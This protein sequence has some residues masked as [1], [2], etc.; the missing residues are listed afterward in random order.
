M[1]EYRLDIIK[2][3]LI[4]LLTGL[5]CACAFAIVS[6]SYGSEAGIIVGF[7]LLCIYMGVA[8]SALRDCSFFLISGLVWMF[9]D[10]S[11]LGGL[12]LWVIAAL[13]LAML[14]LVVLPI[15]LTWN[16]VAVGCDD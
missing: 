14:S 2:R 8:I 6:A 16:L 3:C 9:T 5:G 10:V 13:L 15:R 11:S 4:A 7:F 1:K 12:V